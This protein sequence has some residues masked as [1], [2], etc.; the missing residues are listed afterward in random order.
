IRGRKPRKC[1]LNCG[2]EM[3]SCRTKMRAEFGQDKES[4]TVVII[5]Y[6][7]YLA[8]INILSSNYKDFTKINLKYSEVFLIK[9]LNT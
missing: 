5:K 7:F 9:N 6:I 3:S 2:N 1:N 4:Q 8:P